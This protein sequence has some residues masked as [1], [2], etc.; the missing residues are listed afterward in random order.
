MLKKHLLP[1]KS[2]NILCCYFFTF[3]TLSLALSI[4][5]GIWEGCSLADDW[6]NSSKVYT[7]LPNSWK[8]QMTNTALTFSILLRVHERPW[9][10]WMLHSAKGKGHGWTSNTSIPSPSPDVQSEPVSECCSIQ[11][12]VLSLQVSLSG[13]PPARS[14]DPDWWSAEWTM[15]GEHTQNHNLELKPNN[16]NK[17]TKIT[18]L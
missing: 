5:T 9:L 7:A 15:P 1:Q 8:I 17:M 10:Y 11:T 4:L 3:R 2:F 16:N 14:T 18:K 12:A 6:R 13:S